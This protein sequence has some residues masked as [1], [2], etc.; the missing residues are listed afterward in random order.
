MAPR[1]LLL[2]LLSAPL[3]GACTASTGTTDANALGRSI[4][5]LVGATYEP[6]PGGALKVSLLSV[7]SDSRCPASVQCVTAGSATITLGVQMGTG[8]TVRTPVS[9]GPTN[10]VTTGNLRATFDSLTPY[11]AVPG[12]MPPQSAY[13]AWITFRPQ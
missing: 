11:P 3:L 6:T 1:I 7:D 9:L 10:T 2:A 5:L 8:P 13:R 4:P 12:P